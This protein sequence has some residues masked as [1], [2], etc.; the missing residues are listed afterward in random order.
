MSEKKLI[1]DI[2]LEDGTI[3]LEQYENVTEY[4]TKYGVSFIDAIIETEALSDL[5]KVVEVLAKSLDLPYVAIRDLDLDPTVTSR[6]N[7]N[8]ARHYNVIPISETSG[9]VT[10]AVPLKYATNLQI[11]DELQRASGA[12]LVEFVISYSPDITQT[13]DEIFRGDDKLKDI[14]SD[15]DDDNIMTTSSALLPGEIGEDSKTIK[16]IDLILEQ[17]LKDKASD[18]HFDP[19]ERNLVVRYRI[20]GILYEKTKAP[21]SAAKE[22]TSRIKVMAQLDIS[23]KRNPQDGRISLKINGQKVDFRIATLP[24]IF[25]EKIVIRVLDN[26]SSNMTLKR[27]GLYQDDY[28]KLSKIVSKPHGVV[29]VT[30]PTGSGKST[31]LY[32]I[33]NK[34]VSPRI[35]IITAEDPVEYRMSKGI[36]QVQINVKQDLT[37]SKV[38]RTILRSDPDIILVGEI[39]D[40]ETANIV[41]Q[42]GMTGHMVF[43]TLHTNDAASALSRL[44]EMGVEPFMVVSTLEA[45]VSQRLA[46]KVCEKCR[47]E[48]IA[49]EDELNAIKY[50]YNPEEPL[51][52]FYK[53]N[54]CKEC[55][56]TGY[57]GRVGIF[58]VLPVT[59][60]IRSAVLKG[61]SS[62]DLTKLAIE[63]GMLSMRMDGF[64]KAADGLTTIEEV[65]RV[66]S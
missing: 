1:Q 54:G 64:R 24:S 20:D 22:I 23:D 47:T 18:I 25:G 37:F 66:V 4:S 62:N 41:L 7:S 40:T 9:I 57:I 44:Q 30:G 35:N 55:N 12:R 15:E 10:F 21:L 11:K 48:Y 63:E 5:R 53:A 60:T 42:A 32:S 65:I 28:D 49:T 38:L 45:V 43:S 39:R 61:M 58:E 14:T 46:R 56:Q 29:L 17:A 2:L 50:P 8:L 33:L 36:T 26:T 19:E 51:P 3:T 31:T 52:T 6:I 13:I 34:L 59:E 16:F 27:L